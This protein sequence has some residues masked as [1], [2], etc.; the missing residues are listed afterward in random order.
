MEALL[1]FSVALDEGI[2]A[3][4]LKTEEEPFRSEM[5]V[6]RPIRS[7][8]D[9]FFLA[10]E[11]PGVEI[12]PTLTG[13][14][15]AGADGG[16]VAQFATSGLT[17]SV[18]GT[19]T[20]WESLEAGAL[21]AFAVFQGLAGRSLPVRLSTRF[22]NRVVTPAGA[23]FRDYFRTELPVPSGV[24]ATL[25]DFH[26][27]AS[28]TDARSGLDAVVSV[29]DDGPLENGDHCAVIDLTVASP[30]VAEWAPGVQVPDEVAETFSRL[31]EIKNRL[32][33]DILTPSAFLAYQDPNE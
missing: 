7:V 21:A 13:Y 17:Y 6:E 1:H 16:R 28:F 5:P 18:V 20:T 14:R 4:A 25:R 27:Y 9:E 33:F 10:A 2:R 31:R 26:S 3:E 12:Q 22:I 8:G 23:P 30:F 19:Y 11:G 24:Q 15:Y 29:E 32:F